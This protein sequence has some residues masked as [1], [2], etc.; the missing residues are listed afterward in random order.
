MPKV[1]HRTNPTRLKS[2]DRKNVEILLSR[3]E[4]ARKISFSIQRVEIADLDLPSGALVFLTAYSSL[5]ELRL[6]LGTVENLNLRKSVP[7]VGFDTTQPVWF[8][9]F[10]RLPDQHRL[11]AACEGLSARGEGEDEHDRKALLHVEYEDIGEELWNLVCSDD[12]HPTIV[13]NSAHPLDLRG[14]FDSHDPVTRALIVPAAVER[15]LLLL[16]LHPPKDESDDRWQVKWK[17]AISQLGA[18]SPPE[19]SDLDDFEQAQKW[20]RETCVRFAQSMKLGTYA[21]LQLTTERG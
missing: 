14:K 19:I 9:L 10:V 6:E 21:A 11:L 3:D 7:L 20:A 1:H 8:R 5:S 2:I 16:A 12:Q 15:T 18:D 13:L 4:S 17:R